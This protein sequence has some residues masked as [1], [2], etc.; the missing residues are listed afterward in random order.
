MV[1]GMIASLIG[2]I[3]VHSTGT[4]HWPWYTLIGAESFFWCL[5]RF[6]SSRNRSRRSRLDRAACSRRMRRRFAQGALPV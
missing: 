4:V 1:A 2:M 3:W 5:F 6:C